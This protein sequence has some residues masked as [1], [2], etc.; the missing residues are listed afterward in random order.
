MR[1]TLATILS[2]GLLIQG[3]A[4]QTTHA[5]LVY[6]FDDGTFEGW[7]LLL[8]DGSEFPT[9]EGDVTWIVSDET[10][11]IGDGFN[12]VPATSGDFKVVPDP[13][14]NRDCINL[15]CYTSILRSPAF[16]LD[17]TGDLTVDMI[18][19]GAA[20]DQPYNEFDHI[21]PTEP[22]DLP[23]L[24]TGTGGGGIQGFGLLD[25]AANEYVAWGF[26]SGAN[27]GKARPEDPPFRA[28]WETVSIDQA[29]LAAFANNGKQYAV[30]IFDSYSGGWGWIGFDT[31]SIPTGGGGVVTDYDG[32]GEVGPGDLD[33]HAA[34]VASN[35]P[36]GDLNEDGTTN[37]DDRVAWIKTVQGSWV[38]DVNFDGE[39]NS[40]DLV[41]SLTAGKYE[42]G[43]AATYSQGDFN[44]DLLFSSADFVVAFADGGYEQGPLAA[45]AAVPE[46]TGIVLLLTGLLV[47][48]RKR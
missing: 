24:K 6:G 5:Q 17:G 10:I 4:V 21:A 1:R 37:Y 27:D 34:L 48:R 3:W 18:G 42:T 20:G 22:E 14:G 43:D 16:E 33:A 47:L 36:I 41:A 12:L 30:D 19:G 32:D 15:F 8:P 23:E 40:S 26:S 35:D 9:D 29:E 7:E 28:D 25:V 44:G 39:F 13:W 2:L 46:P 11:D 31:V 38:G 45:T